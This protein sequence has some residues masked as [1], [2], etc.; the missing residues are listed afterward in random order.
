ML[1]PRPRLTGPAP[2]PGVC[3]RESEDIGVSWVPGM[4]SPTSVMGTMSLQRGTWGGSWDLPG[5]Y[6]EQMLHD[7]FT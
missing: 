6:H 1:I 5:T 4:A 7:R 2:A 3:P